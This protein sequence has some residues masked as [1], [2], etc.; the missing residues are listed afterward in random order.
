MC[1]ASKFLSE[2]QSLT[3]RI[4]V[5]FDKLSKLNSKLDKEISHLYHLIEQTNFNAYEGWSFCKELQ[6]ALRK[7]REVKHEI[8][9]LHTLRRE[10]DVNKFKDNINS[11]QSKVHKSKAE[12]DLYKGHWPE[13]FKVED[14]Q[15]H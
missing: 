1:I 11:A 5:E 7:R 14:L 6:I 8:S 9:R 15:I 10:I 3:D 4:N 12:N 13:R 2:M